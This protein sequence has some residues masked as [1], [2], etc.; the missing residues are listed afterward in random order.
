MTEPKETNPIPPVNKNIEDHVAKLLDSSE[1]RHGTAVLDFVRTEDEDGKE[2]RQVLIGP[3][4]K[5]LEEPD[6][7]QAPADLPA[8]TILD[9]DSF[10]SYCL[11]YG[12][13]EKSMVAI[14]G[15][16]MVLILDEHVERGRRVTITRPVNMHTDYAAWNKYLNQQ[17]VDHRTMADLLVR[18][19]HN[20]LDPAILKAV[21]SMRFNVTVDHE[22]TVKDEGNSLGIKVKSSAGEEMKHFPKEFKIS[23]PVL[24]CDEE[25]TFAGKVRLVINMPSAPE[26]PATFTLISPDFKQALRKRLNQE[27][28]KVRQEL[29][30]GWA[31]FNSTAGYAPFEVDSRRN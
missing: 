23:L 20:L 17:H 6:E 13:P 19:E 11:R 7:Y 5:I 14:D 12:N 8:H 31:V 10:I 15:Y 18:Q 2:I 25:E 9:T 26:K 24:D 1:L 29:G 30:D 3:A 21:G 27:V 28:D 22:S 16:R 4:P